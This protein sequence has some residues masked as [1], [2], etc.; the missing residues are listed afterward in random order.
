MDHLIVPLAKKIVHS[1]WFSYLCQKG[2]QRTFLGEKYFLFGD[3]LGT[4]IVVI[5]GR[6]ISKEQVS[7]HLIMLFFSLG[8]WK[9]LSKMSK[10]NHD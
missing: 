9:D 10:H 8:G 6:K 3:L 2:L 4:K 5:I 1:S 7:N